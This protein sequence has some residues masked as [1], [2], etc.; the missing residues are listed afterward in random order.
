[1]YTAYCRGKKYAAKVIDKEMVKD[2]NISKVISGEVE[3]HFKLVHPH[4][5][6]LE[7]VAE[8]EEQLVLL[9]EL[10]TNGNLARNRIV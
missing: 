4:I 10:A 9:A 6:R 2:K 3:L 7:Y 1:M 8:N 5:I